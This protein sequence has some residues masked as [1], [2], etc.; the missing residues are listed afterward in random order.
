MTQ[1]EVVAQQH[2]NRGFKVIPLHTVVEGRCTCGNRSCSSAGKHP[3]TENWLQR[4]SNESEAV[5]RAFKAFKNANI[6]IVV[7]DGMVAIDVDGPSGEHSLGELEATYGPLP[8][9]LT[10][11]TGRGQ[12]LIFR[13]PTDAGVKNRVAFAPG[14]DVRADGGYIVAPGSVHANGRRYHWKDENAPIADA[15]TWLLEQITA[16]KLPLVER[17]PEGQRNDWVYAKICELFRQG[18]DEGYILRT[19]LALNREKCDPPLPE[20]EIAATVSR[21]ALSNDPNRAVEITTKN[22]LRW[23]QFD[24]VEF[25]AN[26]RIQVLKD[27]ELGWRTQ[28]LALAWQNQGKLLDDPDYLARAANA[29]N[30]KRFQRDLSKVLFDFVPVQQKGQPFLVNSEMAAEYAEK[31]DGW[32]QKREA[33]I[34]RAKARAQ[35]RLNKD[36]SA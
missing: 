7:S 18:K 27:F 34:A 14:L 33:G 30:R 35:E 3:R 31:L 32:K 22:P 29:S 1:I 25:R 5:S 12:H 24:V 8:F 10:S 17:I 28:L 36:Q 9:T 13:C 23:F 6:G 20:N 15:P 26:M 19:A 16:P 2:A 11:I 4:A 21:V